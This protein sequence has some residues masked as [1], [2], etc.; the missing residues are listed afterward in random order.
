MRCCTLLLYGTSGV[1]IEIV[2]IGSAWA[3]VIAEGQSGERTL[4]LAG[5]VTG[6]PVQLLFDGR[7]RVQDGHLQAQCLLT[8]GTSSRHPR[9]EQ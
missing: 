4:V 6:K 9:K 3:L 7:Q 8:G 2:D 1:S 5:L